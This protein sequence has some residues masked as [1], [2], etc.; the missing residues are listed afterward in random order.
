MV[1]SYEPLLSIVIPAYKTPQKYLR[2]MLDSIQAQTYKHF[3]VCVANGSPAG[4]GKIVEKVMKQYAQKDARFRYENL[5]ENL[6]IAGNTNAAL[7]MAKGDFIVLADHDDT[8]PPH[9]LL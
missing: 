5:G 6:G 2:E 7:R 3:E 9:A 8:L 4:E 1:F